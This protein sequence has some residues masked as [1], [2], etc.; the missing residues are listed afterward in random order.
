[1]ECSVC[2]LKKH[3]IYTSPCGHQFCGKC[4]LRL[5]ADASVQ[6]ALTQDHRSKSKCPFCRQVLGFEDEDYEKLR[7]KSMEIQRLD[8]RIL[9][10]RID[11]RQRSKTLR[12]LTDW[13]HR[14]RKI[15]TTLK[16]EMLR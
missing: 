10:M 4:F 9:R 13:A 8:S 12:N 2:T 1:M 16:I 5:H 6:L 7:F 11:I 15:N 14:M 3:G